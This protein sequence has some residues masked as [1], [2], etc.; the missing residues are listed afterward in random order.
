[1]HEFRNDL[2]FL[3][4][5]MKIRKVEKLLAN[6]Y[7]QKECYEHE[8]FK[9]SLIHGLILKTCIESLNS[10]KKLGQTLK[11]LIGHTLI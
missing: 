1:M 2:Q 10:I 11:T 4:E 6:F 9:L 7:D 5:R 3:P 8:K